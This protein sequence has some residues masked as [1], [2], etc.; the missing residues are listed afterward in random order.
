MLSHKELLS[1]RVSSLS[2]LFGG[3][4]VGKTYDDILKDA[5]VVN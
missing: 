2:K 3:Y 1:S 4:K 5:V